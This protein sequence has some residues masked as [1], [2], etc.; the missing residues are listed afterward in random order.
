MLPD[1]RSGVTPERY[2]GTQQMGCICV[3]HDPVASQTPYQR[4]LG[5]EN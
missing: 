5:T 3:K 4:D 2:P 1:E